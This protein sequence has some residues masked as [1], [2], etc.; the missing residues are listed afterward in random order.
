MQ[1]S[2][3]ADQRREPLDFQK[4]VEAVDPTRLPKP[5]DDELAVELHQQFNGNYQFFRNQWHLYTGGYWKARKNISRELR[6]HMIKNKFRGVKPTKNKASSI[7]WFL[8][9]DLELEDESCVDEAPQYI[10]MA[11]GLFNLNT[12]ELEPHRRDVYMTAQVDYP[13]D[14]D[15]DCPAFEQFVRT[16]LTKRDGSPDYAIQHLLLEALGYSLTADTS[17]K[18]SFWLVGASG[19]GKS[20][21]IGILRDLMGSFHTTLDLNQLAINRFLLAQVAG[22]RVVTCT[23]ADVN[24]FLADGVYKTLVGGDDEIVAD[25]KNREPIR[26]IPQCKVWWAMNE[27]PR[28]SDRSDA[29]F[30]RV[31][32]FPFWH[33]IPAHQRDYN[34]K[35]KLHAERSGI[36]NLALVGLQRL[37][38]A[39]DWDHVDQVEEMKQQYREENDT[40]LTY[41]NERLE[42]GLSYEA[43]T[44]ALYQDYKAWAEE[45][46]FRSKNR[47]QIIKEWERLGLTKVHRKDGDYWRGARLKS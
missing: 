7:E 27:M 35:A 30:G 31:K 6:D 42:M 25:V 34:L 24:S 16:S 12:L 1:R 17:R 9:A 43:K 26:F 45:N 29:V 8:Q 2:K 28:V 3:P 37:R 44:T 36:F 13:Y 32:I 39:G 41:V 46:G 11:N 20:T 40:E 23:E 14:P 47:N 18:T 10:N 15:A 33:T 4:A 38:R 19:S 22:K 21:L 5:T